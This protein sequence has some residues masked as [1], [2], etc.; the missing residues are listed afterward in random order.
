MVAVAVQHSVSKHPRAYALL[1]RASSAPLV[2]AVVA[3]ADH[4]ADAAR[5]ALYLIAHERMARYALALTAQR[6]TVLAPCEAAERERYEH[7][8]G[9]AD[10]HHFVFRRARDV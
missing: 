2:A 7:R 6:A 9:G 3:A 4:P 10:R 1:S 5:V 8:V